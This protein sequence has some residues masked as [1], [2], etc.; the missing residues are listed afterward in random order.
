MS[1]YLWTPKDGPPPKRA[2]KKHED[3]MERVPEWHQFRALLLSGKMKPQEQV[4]F[5]ITSEMKKAT[6]VDQPWRV[7]RGRLRNIL[8][9]CGLTSDFRVQMFQPDP[10]NNPDYHF[11][12]VTYEPPIVA[13]KKHA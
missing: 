6:G 3:P 5:R 4:G 7:A 13:A 1:K 10:E 12:M 9:E 2:G 8:K 11:I